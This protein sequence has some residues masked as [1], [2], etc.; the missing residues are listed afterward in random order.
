MTKIQYY[1]A[2]SLDGY[3][4][5]TDDGLDW[6]TSYEGAYDG[7]QAE[8]GPMSN[9]GP[10]DRFYAEVG[11]L[12]MGSA[13]YEWLLEHLDDPAAGW[14]YK[15]KPC[16]VMSSREHAPLEGEGIDVRFANG[17]VDQLHPELAEAAGGKNVWLV[18]GGGLASQFSDAGLLDEVLVTIV[19]VVLG[20]GKPLFERGLAKPMQL[21]GTSVFENGMT[22]LRLSLQH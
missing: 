4:A 17:Q 6:L 2:S 3:I 9:D 5:D 11:S 21:I 1:V 8:P 18:G 12:V 14:P 7:P 19:P 16:W 13:T 22:E 20:A 15:G 10:Y